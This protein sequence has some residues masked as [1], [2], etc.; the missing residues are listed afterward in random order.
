MEKILTREIAMFLFIIF[1]KF[2]NIKVN[3]H[4]GDPL[5]PAH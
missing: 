5:Q 4:Y 2:E 1:I 3:I